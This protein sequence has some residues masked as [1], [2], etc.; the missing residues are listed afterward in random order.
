MNKVHSPTELLLTALRIFAVT[1]LALNASLSVAQESQ[2]VQEGREA[3][4][5]EWMRLKKNPG[6]IK[7]LTA[8]QAAELVNS[9]KG[10]RLFLGG[11]LQKISAPLS[12][13]AQ[14]PS[15]D[16]TTDGSAS[17]LTEKFLCIPSRCSSCGTQRR[18]P[19]ANNSSQ[20]N[21]LPAAG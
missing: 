9:V 18:L 15:P 4:L 16:A 17:H 11:S 13:T 8:E 14:N 21:A 19:M 7:S 2:A 5:A 10:G 20:I 6:E 12:S 3:N 1:M